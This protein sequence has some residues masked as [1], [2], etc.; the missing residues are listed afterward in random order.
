[1]AYRRDPVALPGVRVVVQDG[2]HIGPRGEQ[3]AEELHLRLRRRSVMN[4]PA[5]PL[6]R[7]GWRRL[8]R[9]ERQQPQQPRVLRPESRKLSLNRHRNFSRAEKLSALVALTT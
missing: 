5:A 9:V 6:R 3:R 8:L 1:A 4:Q 2:A 7:A